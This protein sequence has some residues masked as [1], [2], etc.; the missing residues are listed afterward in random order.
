M[1]AVPAGHIG[2]VSGHTYSILS[3]AVFG[4]WGARLVSLNMI[5]IFVIFYSVIAL[6]MMDAFKGF[7]HPNIPDAVF[8]VGLVVAMSLNNFF[9]F[10]GVANFARFVAAPFLVAWIGYSFYLAITHCSPTVLSAVPHKSFSLAFT[11]ISSFVLGFAVWGNESD[12]WRHSQP[13]VAFSLV[14]MTIALILGEVIFPVTGWMISQS[15]GISDFEKATTFM[16]DYSF[17]GMTLLAA[18]VVAA[19]YFAGNDANLYGI[20]NSVGGIC[21]IPHKL[22]VA[23]ITTIGALV[24][25]FFLSL[26]AASSLEIAFMLNCFIVP[27]PTVI[28]LTE[29]FLQAKI[30]KQK[31]FFH[32]VPDFHLLP[33]VRIPAVTALILGTAVGL[34][35]SNLIPGT[36]KLNVGIPILQCWLT[37][38]IVYAGLRL[39]EHRQLEVLN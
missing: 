3:R 20:V 17:G 28:V 4:R 9:G 38:M 5:L 26:G 19:A 36:S 22:A 39:A 27:V 15:T 24:A 29:W 21:K 31:P 13:K 7:F 12:Y 6:L 32:T 1:Y 37:S 34:L 23:A 30:F 25:L 14:P 16:K 2:A 10:S 18:I 35:T 8:L 11:A 33:A